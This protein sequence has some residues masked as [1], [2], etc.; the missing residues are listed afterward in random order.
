MAEL[1][2][3]GAA[4]TVTGSK[5]LL[6]SGGARIL[7]DCGLFQGLKEFRLRNWDEFPVPEDSIDAVVLTHADRSEILRWL[8]TFPS[9]PEHLY[10]VHGEPGP[11]DAL[12]ETIA[13]QL[14]WNV[15]TPG[16]QERVT[17]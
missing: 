2:F 12:R 10:L 5:Y 11:M 15:H 17:I 9:A 6:E 3:L 16:H 4:R 13:S 7:I 14:R 8:G 1:T